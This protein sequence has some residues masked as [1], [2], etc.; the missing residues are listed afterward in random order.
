M[1]MEPP[2]G[3]SLDSS[4]EPVKACAACGSSP[5]SLGGSQIMN[6]RIQMI[7]ATAVLGISFPAMAQLPSV[8]PVTVCDVLS[9][10]GAYNTLSRSTASR[11]SGTIGADISSSKYPRFRLHSGVRMCFKRWQTASP[12]SVVMPI[13]PQI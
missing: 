11:R 4:Y 1:A 3:A 12:N 2:I 7:V 8:Q 6:T 10:T 9:N 13:D 5:E